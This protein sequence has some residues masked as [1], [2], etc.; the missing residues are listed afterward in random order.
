M[1]AGRARHAGHEPP[2]LTKLFRDR[3]EKIEPGFGIERLTLV[4]VMTEPLEEVQKASSLVEDQVTDVVPLID[5][6]ANRGQ[7]VY[8]VMPVA[9]DVPERSVR[10]ID[11]AAVAAGATWTQHWPRPVRLLSRPEL[12]EVIALMPDHPPVSITW[13]GKRRRV[14]RAADDPAKLLLAPVGQRVG[15]GERQGY[16]PLLEASD[17]MNPQW[18]GQEAVTLPAGWQVTARLPLAGAHARRL[19]AAER[20][21][22]TPR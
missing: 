4:A 16:L 13:R 21:T 1:D 11:P 20:V 5:V 9:S 7:R 10:P 3:T 18:A 2:A 22:P 19:V 14:K 15:A 12:I 6:F 8:R 17:P